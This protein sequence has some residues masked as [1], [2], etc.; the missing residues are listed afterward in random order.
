MDKKIKMTKEEY[1]KELQIYYNKNFV[2]KDLTLTI[3]DNIK[4]ATKYLGAAYL[5]FE[6]LFDS[7]K[8]I[9]QNDPSLYSQHRETI[10][11]SLEV[12]KMI[13]D[14]LRVFVDIIFDELKKNP[15]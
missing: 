3:L 2:N 15:M 8:L 11:S 5:K 12:I 4:D 7:L 14:E 1:E 13:N 9:K 10:D 6:F